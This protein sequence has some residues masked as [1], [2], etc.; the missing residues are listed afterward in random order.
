MTFAMKPIE[1]GTSTDI[2]G[3]LNRALAE[4]A[5]A[6]MLAQNFHWN[7]TGETFLQLHQLF[8]EIYEDHF[9]AQD[10]LA[11]RIK[12]LDGHADGNLARMIERSAI[13]QDDDRTTAREMLE[14]LLNAQRTLASTLKESGEV[15][16]HAGDALTED[17]CI[18]RGQVHE[19]F[20]WM[21]RVHL[22]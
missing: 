6:T 12:A 16:A 19:K 11:E 13:K 2:C 22:R 9:A 4:T 20:A 10:E 5:V 7:V 14:A 18:A 3:A 17:L 21:L 1:T 8:Q 15:A